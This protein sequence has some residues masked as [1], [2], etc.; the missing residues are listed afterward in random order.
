[1]HFW[2][3][4]SDVLTKEEALDILKQQRQNDIE[5]KIKRMETRGY[6]AYTT[7]TG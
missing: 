5:T 3:F 1:M 4:R 6:P 2:Y 7:A